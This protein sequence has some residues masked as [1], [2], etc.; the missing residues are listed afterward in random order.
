MLSASL[1]SVFHRPPDIAQETYIWYIEK[2]ANSTN[3]YT[4]SLNGAYAAGDGALIYVDE[5]IDA[6][7][8]QVWV[9]SD[10]SESDGTDTYK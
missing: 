9:I 7:D 4:L 10:T 6:V 1:I 2:A 5:D 8:A 3:N